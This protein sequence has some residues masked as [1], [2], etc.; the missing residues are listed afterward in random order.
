MYRG[1]CEPY[2]LNLNA[3]R[4]DHLL[5]MMPKMFGWLMYFYFER[6]MESE[7]T[8]GELDTSPHPI[9]YNQCPT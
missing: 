1:L 5:N 3:N 9:L 8:V 7:R 2:K 4:R 6:E